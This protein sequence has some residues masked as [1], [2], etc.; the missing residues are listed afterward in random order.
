MNKINT[1]MLFIIIIISAFSFLLILN[2]S[3]KIKEIYD[4]KN[5]PTGML[6]QNYY[7]KYTEQN[8]NQT[9]TKLVSDYCNMYKNNID[10]VKC[11]S[12]FVRESGLY[13]YTIQ[14]RVMLSDELMER[15]GDCRSWTM[16][17]SGVFT[18][19]GIASKTIHIE[20]HMYIT[21]YDKEF[22]C[23]VDKLAIGCHKYKRD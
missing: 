8:M 5:F 23:N 16:F 3:E 11:V 22:Y 6:R 21:V 7:Q 4:S 17:Y 18:R 15:G 12:K 1:T 2:N 13:N 20:K 9:V 10:K 14:N 19:L